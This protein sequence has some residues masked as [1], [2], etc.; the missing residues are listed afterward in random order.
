MTKSLATIAIVVAALTTLAARFPEEAS[1]WARRNLLFQGVEWPRET[2]L[3][4]VGVPDGVLRVPVGVDV[5]LTARA[6]G[7]IPDSVRYEVV[8]SDETEVEVAAGRTPDGIFRGTLRA[9]VRDA[10][11][12]A[13]GG[14]GR[15][16][17]IELQLLRRPELTEFVVETSLPDYLGESEPAPVPLGTAQVV[18]GG[19][20]QV[21]LR[22]DKQ[23]ESVSI[24]E[25][26]APAEAT[27]R[28]ERETELGADSFRP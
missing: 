10:R 24:L 12:I 1:L 25:D 2:T 8:F 20:I 7:V 22:T 14:D 11:I 15:S 4:F 6:E 27:E 13:R 17:P 5:T 26:E 19:S 23:L 18:R 9:P 16:Q 28:F 3:F 21:F